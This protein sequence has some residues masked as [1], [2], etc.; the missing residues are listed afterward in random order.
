[1]LL[2]VPELIPMYLRKAEQKLLSGQN[3]THDTRKKGLLTGSG[4]SGSDPGEMHSRSHLQLNPGGQPVGLPVGLLRPNANHAG[5]QNWS[6][7][8]ARPGPGV[9]VFCG[10][11][12]IVAMS[13]RAW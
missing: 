7:G 12:Q 3:R 9:C 13:T 10:G 5:E 2:G 11:Q 4:Q 1:M 6:C 8:A